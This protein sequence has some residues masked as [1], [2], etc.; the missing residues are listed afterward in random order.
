MG[1]LTHTARTVVGLLVGA[2]NGRTVTMLLV[3]VVKESDGCLMAPFEFCV[4]T[5][6]V[7]DVLF[8]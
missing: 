3:N 6:V 4:G 2:A 7:V 8:V 1:S 5:S